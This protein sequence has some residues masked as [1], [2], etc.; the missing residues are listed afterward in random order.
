MYEKLE[1][2]SSS[3]VKRSSGAWVEDDQGPHKP[4]L[5]RSGGGRGGVEEEEEP[6][7]SPPT[8]TV[9]YLISVLLGLCLLTPWNVVINSYEYF[10]QLYPAKDP[11][12]VNLPFYM[13]SATTFPSLPILFLMVWGGH[14]ISTKTRIVVMCLLQAGLM[15][16]MPFL[17]P[18]SPKIPI[19]LACMSGMATCVLQSSVM[20]LVSFF[21]PKYSQ[22][23]MLGQGLSGIMASFGQALVQGFQVLGF[24][25]DSPTYVYFG[26]SALILMGGSAGTL[27]LYNHPLAQ[28]YILDGRGGGGGGGGGAPLGSFRWMTSSSLGRRGLEAAPA[29]A[30]VQDW[31]GL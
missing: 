5:Q 7:H 28:T 26:I 11:V 21:P 17:S 3:V 20:G 12:G 13:T 29:A 30:L 23:F 10:I 25:G 15:V 24:T 14:R 8:D 22:G 9:I 18:F 6:S 27:Y 2:V 31:V 19:L 4:P 16:L 1:G